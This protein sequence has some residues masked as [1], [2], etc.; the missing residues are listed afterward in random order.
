MEEVIPTVGVL[1]FKNKEV[2]LVKH[3][4]SASHLTDTYGIPAGKIEKGETELDAAIRELQEETGLITT[5]DNLQE[6]PKVYT[7]EIKRKDGTK[8][9]SVKVFLCKKYSGD[10]IKSDETV[11][12]WIKISDLDKYKL[13]PNVKQ[14]IIDAQ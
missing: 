12:C 1:I 14:I 9:F 11:P 2:L 7:A 5:K 6:L 13:L 3:G 4:S 10:L 8:T